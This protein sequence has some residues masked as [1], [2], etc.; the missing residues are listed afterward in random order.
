MEAIMKT[1]IGAGAFA[2]IALAMTVP[3]TANVI[4]DQS[5]LTHCTVELPWSQTHVSHPDRGL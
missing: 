4:A 3:A 1:V 2:L 5:L